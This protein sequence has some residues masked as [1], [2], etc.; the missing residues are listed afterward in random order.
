MP[1][2]NS[3]RERRGSILARSCA[4]ICDG[5]PSYATANRPELDPVLPLDLRSKAASLLGVHL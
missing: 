2:D 4:V 3:P 5:S 1:T